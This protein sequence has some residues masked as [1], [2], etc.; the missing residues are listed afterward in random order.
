MYIYAGRQKIQVLLFETFWIFFFVF[1]NVFEPW[2][3]ESV[4]VE[5]WLYFQCSRKG[6]K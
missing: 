3:V 6:W 1:L 5:G 2:L 4:D